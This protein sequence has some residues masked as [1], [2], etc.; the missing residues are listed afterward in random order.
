MLLSEA[1][2]NETSSEDDESDSSEADSDDESSGSS[3]SDLDSNPLQSDRNFDEEEK[4]SD[5]GSAMNSVD[6]KM[7]KLLRSGSPKRN[8]GPAVKKS[9]NKRLLVMRPIE[10]EN[11]LQIIEEEKE[12]KEE[13][14]GPATKPYRYIRPVMVA[15]GGTKRARF[16][17]L[18]CNSLPDD[19][20]PE[21]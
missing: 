20:L 3:S 7:K 11:E 1:M 16:D 4:K 8:K 15:L 5:N 6:I 13:K 9:S 12:E 17:P 2:Q 14:E 19:A 18:K 10:Q 21:M